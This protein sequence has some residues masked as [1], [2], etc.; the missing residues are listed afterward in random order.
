[1]DTTS[2]NDSMPEQLRHAL[3]TALKSK[4]TVAASA[5]RSALAAIAN[6]E[7]VPVRD[8]DGS[9]EGGGLADSE[10]FAG[11][12]AGLGSAEAERRMLTRE[13]TAAIIRAE[14]SERET[15]AR[16]YESAGHPERAARLRR[17]ADA[18]RS[19]FQA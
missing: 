3:R 6:A 14:I 13:E 2:G 4:D 18:I 15:A 5:L 19:A 16:Q 17:E 8:G 1:M 7:A 12:T 11:G 9:R 10:H